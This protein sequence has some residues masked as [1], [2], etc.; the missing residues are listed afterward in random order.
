MLKQ[1]YPFKN[2]C[3][4]ACQQV[5]ADVYITIQNFPVHCNIKGT[6]LLALDMSATAVGDLGVSQLFGNAAAE[7]LLLPPQLQL[8]R[9]PVKTLSLGGC[10]VTAT[11]MP[12]LN[13]LALTSLDMSG[14]KSLNWSALR[15]L[16]DGRVGKTLVTLTIS[17]ISGVW[18]YYLA[19][20]CSNLEVLVATSCKAMVLHDDCKGASGGSGGERDDED[21]KRAL[22]T[23]LPAAPAATPSSAVCGFK[24][25]K[26]LKLARSECDAAYAARMLPLCGALEQLDLSVTEV[27]TSVL[28]SL[29]T[30]QHM[31]LLEL[32]QCTKVS[33]K[34]LGKMLRSWV[35]DGR[36]PVEPA[37][38]R[39]QLDVRHCRD[40]SAR[41]V[42]AL[43]VRYPWVDVLW[44]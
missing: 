5:Y 17:E 27:Q 44:C 30:L 4:R 19:K 38:A 2:V 25:L 11:S 41:E 3:K 6:N 26:V 37:P 35:G 29:S 20:A 24:R 9:H 32:R 18:L 10:P 34:S 15:I 39:L 31:Q 36:G 43:K 42:A 33:G 7:N 40:V 22:R 28:T 13:Q 23:L 16:V 21:G 12:V 1:L 14:C 8:H